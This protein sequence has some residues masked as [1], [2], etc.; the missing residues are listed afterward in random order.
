MIN[1]FKVGDI[2][3]PIATNNTDAPYGLDDP[4]EEMVSRSISFEVVSVEVMG[5]RGMADGYSSYIWHCKDL[6]LVNKRKMR[7]PKRW[8]L[9]A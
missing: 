1:P 2:V 8:A 7:K 6:K 9:R 3:V 5:I 4:M